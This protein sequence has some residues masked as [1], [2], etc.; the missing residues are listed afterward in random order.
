MSM[1]RRLASACWVL[2][3][4]MV[5][6]CA[7]VKNREEVLPAVDIQHRLY[8]LQHWK[9]DGRIAAKAGDE[10][11]N[12]NLFWEHDA[13]QERLRIY[14]PFS[15]G[16][17][18]IILQKNLVYINEGNGVVSESK[19]PGAW[20]EQRLGFS[21]PLASLR[22]WLLGLPMPEAQ[23]TARYDS[24]GGWRGFEQQGW[25]VDIEAYEESAGFVVPKK[26]SIQGKT[27]RLRLV[28][29]EWGL[30]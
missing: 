3:A 19:D 30:N 9:L 18:S 21:V 25:V 2:T 11:W 15:Q 7:D 17:V 27:V 4:V 22:C 10:G 28:V 8:Q 1:L 23:Y 20:L 14:G 6:G 16:N 29:D 5:F 13:G 26:M 12:A 24:R